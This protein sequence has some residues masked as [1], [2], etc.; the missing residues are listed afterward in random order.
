MIGAAVG[1]VVDF[2]PIAVSLRR[3][4]LRF[5]Y[6][7]GKHLVDRSGLT[8]LATNSGL[9]ESRAA[10][11]EH[12]LEQADIPSLDG[13]KLLDIGCGFGALA[14]LFAS[15][16]AEVL[17]V[18]P[19]A[20]RFAVGRRVAEEF[21]LPVRW[22][23]ASMEELQVREAAFDVAVMNNSLCYLIP[24]SAR[25]AALERTLGALRS[26]GVLVV[27]N[28][29]RIHPM[30]QF[31]G[32][33]LVGLLP[34]AGARIVAKLL[35]R[36]RSNVRLLT[37]RAARRELIRSGFSDVQL[38]RRPSASKLREALAG[39]QHLIARRP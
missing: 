2:P 19:N 30:D 38:V 7:D 27:R 26:G 29:N 31:S 35:R 18:D 15:R 21:H 28:P 25:R 13:L 1:R 5:Y 33:P 20:S 22:T 17:A 32:L 9:A 11:L 39:Y 37:R 8:T 3:E 24:R 4:I 6:D 16:G 23:Q 12:A 14:L 10:I 36:H 34:P